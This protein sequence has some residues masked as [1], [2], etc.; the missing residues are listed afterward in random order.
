[1]EHDAE[2]FVTVVTNLHDERPAHA[3]YLTER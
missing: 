1:M 2:Y 3:V